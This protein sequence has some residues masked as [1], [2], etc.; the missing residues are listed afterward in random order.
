MRHCQVAK[1]HASHSKCFC[2]E[3]DEEPGMN[4]FSTFIDNLFFIISNLRFQD[5]IDISFVWLIVYRVLILIKRSGT[6]QMLSGLGI[7]SI[8]YIS[9]IW[10]E[11][12]TLNWIL[13]KFF[14]NL[15]VIIVV[16]FQGEIRR[17]LAHIGSHPL[18]SGVSVAMET[19]LV[20]EIAKGIISV[21]Q[22]GY[23]A[24]IVIEKD[25]LVDYHIELGTE[26]NS[27]ISSELIE[28]I[29]HTQTPMHDG[30]ILIRSGKIAYAGC[31]LPL[32]QN[33]VID[34]NLG[35][36]HRAAIG[37]TEETDAVV[38]VV[39]E[40]TK[41]VSIVTEGR[42]SPNAELS[43]IR[44]ELYEALGLKYKPAYES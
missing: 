35:T 24:L 28:S 41:S 13:E 31:F 19:H 21:A 8:T 14:S 7:L 36:R 43:D 44:R 39:S 4:F 26:M 18:F 16:L 12:Y 10:F 2:R 22:K 34:K 23:G 17:A 9:S 42:M 38:F 40:E 20:E 37:L 6:V 27:R 3:L 25:I 29:F 32:S 15:F 33:P 30:A 5:F 11:L 1:L